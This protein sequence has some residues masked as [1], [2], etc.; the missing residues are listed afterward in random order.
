MHACV[1]CCCFVVLLLLHSCEW[2]AYHGCEH[3]FYSDHMCYSWRRYEQWQGRLISISLNR[4]SVYVHIH[5]YVKLHTTIGL[6]A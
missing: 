2:L 4:G 5:V 1:L 6:L 3:C